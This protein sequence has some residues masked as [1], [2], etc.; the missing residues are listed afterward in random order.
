MVAE[1]VP[2]RELHCRVLY[3][4]CVTIDERWNY[5]LC[6]PYWRL[7]RD[8]VDGGWIDHPDGPTLLE[9]GRL[10]LVPAWGRFRSR[11]VHAT[12]HFY[13]HFTTLGLDGDWADGVFDRP[14][15]VP[16]DARRD[17]LA[18]KLADG[19]STPARRLHVQ[20]LVAECLAAVIESLPSA[21]QH[22]LSLRLAGPE[23]MGPALRY[24]DQH[25]GEHLSVATLARQCRLSVHHFSR[26][27]HARLGRTPTRYIQE[28]RVAVSAERLVS[29]DEPIERIAADAGFANRYHF[30]RV[31]TRCMGVPPATYR[32]TG[33]V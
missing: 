29:G 30:T 13:V 22:R 33:R 17:A 6:N 21:A 20:A 28:R 18:L 1:A 2:P 8:D 24:I 14:L 11:C 23:Q 3:E 15:A 19:W 26:V 31:F 27:F 25:L 4:H 16:S 7:Y 10:Y 5:A 9:G 32:R 12:R